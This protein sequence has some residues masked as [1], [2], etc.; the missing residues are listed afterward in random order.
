MVPSEQCHLVRPPCLQHHQ[1][2]QSLQA[3][4]P[5]VHKVPHEDVVSVG[6]VATSSKQFLKK[7]IN[8]HLTF[9]LWTLLDKVIWELVAIIF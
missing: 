8:S 1:P 3:V 9:R 7:R 4:V 6:T 2:G 5:S